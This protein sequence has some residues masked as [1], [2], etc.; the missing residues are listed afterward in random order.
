VLVP[1]IIPQ[2]RQD[3]FI[4]VGLSYSGTQPLANCAQSGPNTLAGAIN[5]TGTIFSFPSSL[6]SGYFMI[7]YFCTGY[8]GAVGLSTVTRSN[9]TRLTGGAQYSGAA[10]GDFGFVE[11]LRI[12]AANATYAFTTTAVGSSGK[13]SFAVIECDGL[14]GVA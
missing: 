1:T 3:F 13:V 9:C 2:L 10:V 5:I 4:N 11:Y 8:A 14:P 12:D 6:S 7:H